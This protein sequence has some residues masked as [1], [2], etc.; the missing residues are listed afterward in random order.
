MLWQG[1]KELLN[2]CMSYFI[3]LVTSI[4]FIYVE[5]FYMNIVT[6]GFEPDILW[7]LVLPQ[8]IVLSVPAL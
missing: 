4:H 2:M 6:F 1:I 7:V 8:Q 3:T 5:T